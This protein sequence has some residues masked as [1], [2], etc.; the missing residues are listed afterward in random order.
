MH[1]CMPDMPK[2][3]KDRK[4]NVKSLQLSFYKVNLLKKIKQSP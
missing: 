3:K 4:H 1:T 2:P